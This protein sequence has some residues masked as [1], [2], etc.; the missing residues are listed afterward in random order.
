MRALPPLQIATVLF[1]Y[2]IRQEHFRVAEFLPIRNCLQ[3]DT[4]R[5]PSDLEFLKEAYLQPELSAER[6][7]WPESLTDEEEAEIKEVPASSTL[8]EELGL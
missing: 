3:Q 1:S 2:Y 8:E 5:T 7:V 4:R 6:R